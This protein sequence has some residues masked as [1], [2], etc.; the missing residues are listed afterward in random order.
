M[1]WAAIRREQFP[2]AARWAYLDHAAVAPITQRAHDALLLWSH[3]AL[4]DGTMAWL[5]FA[6]RVA[7]ARTSAARLIN[8]RTDEIAFVSNT[9][10]GI[11][12]VAEGFSWR[13]GD[14]VVTSGDEYPSNLYPW[15]HLKDRGV[16][17]RIVPARD[18]RV[19]IDE[20]VAAIDSRTR[21]LTISHV[22]FA[23]GF[24]NDLDKLG[25]LCR[26]KGI[27]FFVDAIQGLGPLTIDVN[28]TPIDFLAADGHKWL[29]GPEGAGILYV[30]R[31]WIDR[32]RATGIGWH[33]VKSSYNQVRYDID[34]K[35]S[36]ERW[37]GGTW[38]M[39]GIHALGAS[40]DL[41]LEIGLRQVSERVLHNAEIV[42]ELALE[43]GWMV[44]GDFQ[45][46]ERSGIVAIERSGID[47]DGFAK[48][49][50]GRGVVLAAR[51]GKI[52]ISPHFYQDESD[53]A[54]LG[55]MLGSPT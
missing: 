44:P 28:R 37:E 40:I 17:T 55:E 35:P 2:A 27:A 30:R 32:L 38:N 39:P 51:R 48:R 5:T 21:L 16:E 54:R 13:E 41:L 15:I 53:F 11:G 18:G 42:R 34:L 4:H 6:D 29:L 1:D 52:R 10:H 23:S 45:P 47:V 33:S 36:A 26:A 25:E 12:L 8:A 19:E 31:E 24:R 46:D 7:K 20:L 50:R 9:T 43:H 49:C 14:N 22:E 3:S